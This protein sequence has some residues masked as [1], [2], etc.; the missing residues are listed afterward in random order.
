MPVGEGHRR[1]RRAGYASCEW[2]FHTLFTNVLV[3]FVS[4]RPWPELSGTSLWRMQHPVHHPLPSPGAPMPR[5]PPPTPVPRFVFAPNASPPYHNHSAHSHTGNHTL[6]SNGGLS[7]RMIVGLPPVTFS[8]AEMK[9]STW[10]G[11]RGMQK[12]TTCTIST[13]SWIRTRWRASPC[14]LSI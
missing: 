10:H 14:L 11:A 7:S 2:L 12:G 5:S 3:P 8:V 6:V 4:N 1:K 9:V 13:E